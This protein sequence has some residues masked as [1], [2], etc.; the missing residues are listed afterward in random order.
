MLPI[1][2]IIS[3]GL[4]LGSYIFCTFLMVPK[5]RKFYKLLIYI[6]VFIAL[7]FPDIEY[8]EFPLGL[9]VNFQL[10]AIVLCGIE[11]FELCIE[12]YVE[13]K[14]RDKKPISKNLERVYQSL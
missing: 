9:K 5:I 13:G 7:F 6:L 12:F 4:I 14:K 1:M 8:I 2:S 11:L 10:Y 3:V